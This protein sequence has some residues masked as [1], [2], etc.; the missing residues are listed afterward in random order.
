[1]SRALVLSIGLAMLAVSAGCSENLVTRYATVQDAKKDQVFERGW[2]PA[3]LPDTA[4]P[5]TEAHNIDTNARCALAEFPP[6]MFD[7][8]LEALTRD[9]FQTH[10]ADSPA[11]PLKLCPFDI[12]DFRRASIV[13]RKAGIHGDVEF[14]GLDK[15]GTFMFMGIRG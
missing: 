5:L 12:D 14:V 4:G 1:M 2:L 10:D 13:L 9:G 7:E 15:A 11:P 8:V 3:V 6:D